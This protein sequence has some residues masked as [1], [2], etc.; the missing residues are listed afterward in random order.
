MLQYLTSVTIGDFLRDNKFGF[1]QRYIHIIIPAIVILAGCGMTFGLVNFHSTKMEGQHAQNTAQGA[2]ASATP[3]DSKDSTVGN[4]T[5]RAGTAAGKQD[6]KANAADT[7]VPG[8]APS[9][10][11]TPAPTQILSKR[12]FSAASA[13]NAPISSSA[14]WATYTYIADSHWWVNREDFS[15]PVVYSASNYP[16]VSVTLPAS[17]GW[18]AATLQ[19]RI[20]DGVTGAAGNDASLIV[21]NGDIAYNFFEFVRTDSTHAHASAYGLANIKT[22]T[23]W[24]SLN[25]TKGAGIRA[26]G[27]SGLGGLITGEDLSAGVIDHALA[28]SMRASDMSSGFIAPAIASDGSGGILPTGTRFGIPSTT[29]IPGGLSPIGH[30]VWDSLKTYGAYLVD[31]GGNNAFYADPNSVTA[32]QINPLRVYWGT[33]VQNSDLDLIMPHVRIAQ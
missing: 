24:G 17:W 19:M 16:L 31:R 14:Q 7:P 11:P 13:W 27:A 5:P 12:P 26:A 25:P 15:L 21:I 29:P 1:L 8:S 32:D 30:M 20:A 2:A 9:Q 3:K 10:V 33:G 18:P 23:G 22:D 28:V 4:P 6:L